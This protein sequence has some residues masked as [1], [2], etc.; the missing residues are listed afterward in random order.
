MPVGQAKAK[1]ACTAKVKT[2]QKKELQ[3]ILEK[4]VLRMPKASFCGETKPFFRDGKNERRKELL[5]G[6]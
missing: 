3:D 6:S 2:E 1:Q 4:K 5:Q